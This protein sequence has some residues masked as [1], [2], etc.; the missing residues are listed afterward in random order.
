[1]PFRLL[2]KQSNSFSQPTL[3]RLFSSKRCILLAQSLPATMIRTLA[4]AKSD[5]TYHHLF[6]VSEKMPV[7]QG[8]PNPLP[9]ETC[10]ILRTYERHGRPQLYDPW[11]LRQSLVYHKRDRETERSVW[12]FV[13]LFQRCKNALWEEFS[14]T[15]PLHLTRPHKLF[16]EI[17]LPDWR[18]YFDYQRQSVR[19]FVS[20]LFYS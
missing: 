10:Y 16:L 2:P 19:E 11:S 14:Q 1:M 3:F 20:S 18:W 6:V 9:L 8:L 7:T 17:I 13:Q 5:I 4:S 15:Y 12:I